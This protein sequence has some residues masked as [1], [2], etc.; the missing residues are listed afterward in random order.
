MSSENTNQFYFLTVFAS[1]N[2]VKFRRFSKSCASFVAPAGTYKGMY[3]AY[4][5]LMKTE[6]IRALYKGFTPV[7]IR[8]FPA[9]AVRNFIREKEKNNN[10]LTSERNKNKF[11][12]ATTGACGFLIFIS[13]SSFPGLFLGVRSLHEIFDMDRKHCSRAIVQLDFCVCAVVQ[14][15]KR[16]L[17]V[18]G[19]WAR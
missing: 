5:H 3:D 19:F 7:M 6:G 14:L 13:L 16:I 2:E 11:S 1:W 4:T 10:L 9:N 8:A 17:W 15:P 12:K 18:W